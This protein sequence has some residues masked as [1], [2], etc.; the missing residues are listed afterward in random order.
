M[1]EHVEVY[2]SLGAAGGY[3]QGKELPLL[4]NQLNTSIVN[5]AAAGIIPAYAG[6][7]ENGFARLWRSRAGGRNRVLVP[8][9]P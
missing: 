8:P 1:R 2:I 5:N 4:E 9:Q 6:L 7:H 3:S